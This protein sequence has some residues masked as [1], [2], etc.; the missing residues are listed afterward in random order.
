MGHEP[1]T[2]LIVLAL[3]TAAWLVFAAIELA[4]LAL[5]GWHTVSY[6]AHNYPPLKYALV[7]APLIFSAW[8]LY[9]LSQPV[10]K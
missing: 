4:G 8:L 3:L 9:H 1:L 2:G 10:A 7:I 6:L 5:P